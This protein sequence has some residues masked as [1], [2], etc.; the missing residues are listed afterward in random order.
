MSSSLL[1]HRVTGETEHRYQT[2]KAGGIELLHELQRVSMS[3]ETQLD[4]ETN[5]GV[6]PQVTVGES[7]H[8]NTGV[9]DNTWSVRNTK[10]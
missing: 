4:R 9:L 3:Q 2:M 7:H 1:A 8:H 5:F 6:C 10:L